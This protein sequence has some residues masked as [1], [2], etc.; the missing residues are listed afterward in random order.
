[1]PDPR[2]APLA[3]RWL[4]LVV[5]AQVDHG[6]ETER[7]ELAHRVRQKVDADA[8]ST[9]LVGALDDDDVVETGALKAQRRDQSADSGAH[10]EDLH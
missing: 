7:V 5:A 4:A 3:A 10:D 8:E 6:V 1:M 9:D 2:P